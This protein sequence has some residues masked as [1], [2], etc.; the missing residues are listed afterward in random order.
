MDKG[1]EE[2][3]PFTYKLCRTRLD[4]LDYFLYGE[5]IGEIKML[6]EVPV[7]DVEWQRDKVGKF[8]TPAVIGTIWRNGK[9]DVCSFAVNISGEE[10]KIRFCP[11]GKSDPVSA[12]LPPRSVIAIPCVSR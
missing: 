4:H 3:A 7:V 9:G 8:K 12:T 1:K 6:D 2:Y 11:F 10:L 5:L